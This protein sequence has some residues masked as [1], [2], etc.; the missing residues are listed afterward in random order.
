MGLAHSLSVAIQFD[1]V[2]AMQALPFPRTGEVVVGSIRG[3][4]LSSW[5]AL[6]NARSYA[7][8]L[9][10]EAKI[11]IE[12]EQR[13]GEGDFSNSSESMINRY[14]G[15]VGRAKEFERNLLRDIRKLF[16]IPDDLCVGFRYGC[17]VATYP[18]PQLPDDMV[19]VEVFDLD[20]LPV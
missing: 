15:A 14:H 16:S 17:Q 9:A 3:D 18:G 2:L 6:Q 19:N 12:A 11:A 1:P 5:I 8:C 20:T 4:L 7:D 10:R 13:P